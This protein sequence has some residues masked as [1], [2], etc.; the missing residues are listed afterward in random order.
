MCVVILNIKILCVYTNLLTIDIYDRING[1]KNYTSLN[2][3]KITQIIFSSWLYGF[4]H[5]K[6]ELNRRWAD[7]I[8]I[9]HVIYK[10]IIYIILVVVIRIR[11]LY[12]YFSFMG[13][14]LT[15]WAMLIHLLY[16]YMLAFCSNILCIVIGVTLGLKGLEYQQF[17]FLFLQPFQKIST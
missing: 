4:H 14:V 1:S 16:R 8:H 15:F 7:D 3:M 6:R 9:P 2:A 10:R 12:F 5:A 11:V 13:F 17:N